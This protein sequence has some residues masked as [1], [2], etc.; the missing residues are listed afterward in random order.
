[1]A[2]IGKDRA[3]RRRQGSTFYVAV[4]YI[5]AGRQGCIIENCYHH[6]ELGVLQTFFM[7]YNSY[8]GQLTQKRQLIKVQSVCFIK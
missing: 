6:N 8:L 5:A 2:E 4:L 7:V 3:A 1:M